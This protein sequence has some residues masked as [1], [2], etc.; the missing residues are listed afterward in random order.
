M[1]PD[2]FTVESGLPIDGRRARGEASRQAILDA[3]VRLIGAGGLTSVTHRAVAAEAGVSTALTTYHFATLDDLLHATLSSLSATGL[4][5]LAAAA[6]LAESGA[7]TLADAAT[8]F[9]IQE[10]GPNRHVFIANLELQFASVRRSAWS[11][12]M[13][14]TYDAF[15]ELIQHYVGDEQAARAIFSAAFGF[16]VLHVI[17]DSHPTDAACRR[18]VEHL[19]VQYNVPKPTPSRSKRK[20]HE[21]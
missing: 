1:R 12:L 5:R 17:Q 11:A 18:F 14:N 8:A 16:A 6:E 20:E 13:T 21:R 19:L 3:T 4:A 10:L 2:S 9:L 15:V 7:I